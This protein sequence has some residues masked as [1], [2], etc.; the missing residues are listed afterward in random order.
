VGPDR[1]SRRRAGA[2]PCRGGPA[3]RVR[4]VRAG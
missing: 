1:A 4:S 2:D 3:G